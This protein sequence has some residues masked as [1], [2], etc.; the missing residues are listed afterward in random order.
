M[1]LSIDG[2]KVLAAMA[3]HSSSFPDI[4]GDLSKSLDALG[5][6]VRSLVIKQVK[7]KNTNLQRIR[8]VS[9]AI[10][11]ANFK[12][13]VDGIPDAQIKTLVGKLDHHPEIKTETAEWRRQ[14]LISLIDG[15]KPPTPKAA[16]TRPSA[17]TSAP[18]KSSTRKA[19]SHA[20]GELETLDYSSAGAQRKR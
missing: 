6:A 18:K 16:A 13:I 2:L 7:H 15:S 17:R 19:K 14:H 10:G 3:S 5:K 11:A 4:A 8:G 9:D 1:A 20:P 12:L